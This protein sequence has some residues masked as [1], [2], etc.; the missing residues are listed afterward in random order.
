MI[1]IVPYEEKYQVDIDKMLASIEGEFERPIRNP[2]KKKK[3]T[4][5]DKY[6]LALKSNEV[7]GTVGL[8]FIQPRNAILK[9]MMVRKD[10][11]GSAQGLSHLLL[12]KAMDYCVEKEIE[13][14]YLGT[15]TQFKA[16]QKFY[17]KNGFKEI[18]ENELPENF[19]GNSLDSVFFYKKIKAIN[20]SINW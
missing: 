2:T 5:P 18:L 15:M 20:D 9:S 6:W 16:A 19:L 17:Q 3:S 7:V 4:L 12:Q 1:R 13:I 8:I 10:F 11:R 14:I